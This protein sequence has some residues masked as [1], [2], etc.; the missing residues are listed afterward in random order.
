[1]K[2]GFQRLGPGDTFPS[3]HAPGASGNEFHLPEYLRSG[4]GIVLLYRGDWCPFCRVQLAN[5]QRHTLDFEKLDVRVVA[6]SVDGE[7][8][9]KA[10]VERSHLT[11]PVLYGADPD[12]LA[13]TLG[14]YVS[15]DE[16]G[17]YVNSTAFIIDP[18]GRVALAVYSTGAVGRLVAEDALALIGYLQQAPSHA[19]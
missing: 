12:R 15:D 4:W 8:D 5:F 17:R 2:T 9:A 10:T 19:R 1:M 11:F 16:H 14:V 13:E 18:S 3:L 6:I 7:D